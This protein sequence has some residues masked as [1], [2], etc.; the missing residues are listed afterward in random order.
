M[1]WPS[2]S[3]ALKP[4]WTHMGDFGPTCYTALPTTTIKTT[5]EGISSGRMIFHLSRRVPVTCQV[6]AKLHWSCSGCSWWLCTLLKHLILHIV[7]FEDS[8]CLCKLRWIS[9]L[10]TFKMNVL[11]WMQIFP[12]SKYYKHCY[13]NTHCSIHPYPQTIPNRNTHTQT[14]CHPAPTSLEARSDRLQLNLKVKEGYENAST[15]YPGDFWRLYCCCSPF[16]LDM[17]TSCEWVY[18]MP[19]ARRG[20]TL[21]CEIL[22]LAD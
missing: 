18:C 3:L 7:G 21:Y 2:Q 4:N 12:T 5:N 9:S 20:L 22:S 15:V 1:L 11:L 6:N 14:S 17:V 8:A 13:K 10:I 19:A 16:D